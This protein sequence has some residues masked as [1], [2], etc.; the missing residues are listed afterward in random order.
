MRKGLLVAASVGA[1]LLASLAFAERQGSEAKVVQANA[2][3][4]VAAAPAANAP[5]K[6]SPYAAIARQHASAAPGAPTKRAPGQSPALR[7]RRL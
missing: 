1:S 3:T 5:V 6:V 7:A 4:S 2:Q